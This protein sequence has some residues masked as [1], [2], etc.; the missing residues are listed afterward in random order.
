MFVV[1]LYCK[2]NKMTLDE[3]LT[4]GNKLKINYG[5]NN[6]NNKTIHIVT[7]VEGQVVYKYWL[8]H[9]QHWEYIVDSKFY[10]SLLFKDDVL[11]Y[12]GKSDKVEEK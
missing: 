4:P 9:K 2:R 1:K 10:F 11:T 12:L 8:K 7:V 6:W 5:E 3:L